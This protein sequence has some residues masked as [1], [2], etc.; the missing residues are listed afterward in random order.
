MTPH[1]KALSK[2]LGWNWW[3]LIPL[4]CTLC[5]N[6][7]HELKRTSLIAHDACGVLEVPQPADP[8]FILVTLTRSSKGT[9]GTKSGNMDSISTLVGEAL[10]ASPV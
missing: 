2:P 9:I 6:E 1:L 10:L 7:E 4:H 5:W 8:H 3:P